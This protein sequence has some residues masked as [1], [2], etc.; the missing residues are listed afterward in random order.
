MERWNGPR[1]GWR[2]SSGCGGG[3][4]GE[5]RWVSDV[6]VQAGQVTNRCTRATARFTLRPRDKSFLTKSCCDSG[7]RTDVSGPCCFS[8][9]TNRAPLEMKG[10]KGRNKNARENLPFRRRDADADFHSRRD[11]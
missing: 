8:P 2:I 4:L 7:S 11:F 10:R 3:G 6:H 1:R 5:K 9:A